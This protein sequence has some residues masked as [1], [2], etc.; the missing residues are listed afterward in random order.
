[1]GRIF[2]YKLQMYWLNYWPIHMFYTTFS[3]TPH[4]KENTLHVSMQKTQICNKS[5][6]N[7]K[8]WNFPFVTDLL[9]ILPNIYY[10]RDHVVI[11]FLPVGFEKLSIRLR[12]S[13]DG[14]K[15]CTNICKKETLQLW[16]IYKLTNWCQCVLQKISTNG[17]F[18]FSVFSRN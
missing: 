17:I 7:W 16:N 14:N 1:M 11:Y 9:G 5:V 4:V 15:H 10:F 13:K 2:F 18:I 6:T 8:S 12:F 3:I